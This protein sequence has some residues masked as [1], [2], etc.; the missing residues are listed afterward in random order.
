MRN[1]AE[2]HIFHHIHIADLALVLV[3]NVMLVIDAMLYFGSIVVPRFRAS[4]VA[5]F[6][7]VSVAV[8]TGFWMLKD[9]TNS[10]GVTIGRFLIAASVSAM[11]VLLYLLAMYPGTRKIAREMEERLA[12][13]NA[14]ENRARV[15]AIC[16]CSGSLKT[17]LCWSGLNANL[18][19]WIDFG[20]P[21]Q[22]GGLSTYRR[23]PTFQGA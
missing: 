9:P 13:S 2:W 22:L 7:A 17:D 4:L 15:S 8:E 11:F 18:L 14:T 6:Y 12:S 23:A 10:A 5:A 16:G 3:A 19:L 21:G 20:R 1:G